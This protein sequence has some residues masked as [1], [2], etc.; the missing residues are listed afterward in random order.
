VRSRYGLTR[1]AIRLLP[2]IALAVTGE[3]AMAEQ[4]YTDRPWGYAYNH[5][6]QFG[7]QHTQQ[8]K[9]RYNPWARLRREGKTTMSEQ[10]QAPR[11]PE[12]KNPAAPKLPKPLKGDAYGSAYREGYPLG[13]YPGGYPSYGSGVFPGPGYG[14]GWGNP[15]PLL[16]PGGGFGPWGYGGGW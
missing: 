15:Y 6:G 2:V 8:G 11:F 9:R 1:T 14:P 13:I 10:R 3:P 5:G 16:Y 7:S 4:T 12:R